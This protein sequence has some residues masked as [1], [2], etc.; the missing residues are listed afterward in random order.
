MTQVEAPA[1]LSR[2][3]T[4]EGRLVTVILIRCGLRASDAC[5]LAFDC[6][7]HD[8]QGSPYLRYY[9]HKMRREAAGPHRR[10]AGRPK[11]ATSSAGSQAGGRAGTP[12]CS[13][14]ST[15]TPGGQHPLTYYSYRGML[16]RWLVTCD[17][18]DEHGDPVHLT[19]HQW[20]HT[21]AC[22]LINKD[23]PQ[24]VIRV[25]LDHQFDPDDGAL[26]PYH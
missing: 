11:S 3:T 1:S 12:I 21:F 22:R 7:L 20:R 9:N 24:E 8:G 17:I 18:R 19:P 5:T 23:V 13:P 26:R 15:A 25:L 4:P 10:R 16:N 2:W 6:V 14:R